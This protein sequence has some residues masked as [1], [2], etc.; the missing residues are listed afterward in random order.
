M[1]YF[2]KYIFIVPFFLFGLAVKVQAIY[3]APHKSDEMYQQ[4]A[5]PFAA[6]MK[7]KVKG[8]TLLNE[9]YGTG[10]Y[11]EDPTTGKHFVLTAAH[12]IKAGQRVYMETSQGDIPLEE[13]HYFPQDLQEYYGER[14]IAL[15]FSNEIRNERLYGG[16][17]DNP[18]ILQAISYYGGDIALGFLPRGIELPIRPLRLSLKQDLPSPS[19]LLVVGFGASGVMGPVG[20]W[21]GNIYGAGRKRAYTPALQRGIIIKLFDFESHEEILHPSWM[22]IA[23]ENNHSPLP[24]QVGY[25]DSGGPVLCRTEAGHHEIIGVVSSVLPAARSKLFK[26]K[27][28][29]WQ[30]F[31]LKLGRHTTPQS[32]VAYA[33]GQEANT[34]G[35]EA[36]FSGITSPLVHDWIRRIL[37]NRS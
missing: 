4:A 37:K 14:K 1:S 18:S 7:L 34:Y 5:F 30:K 27:A 11:V 31:V 22:E 23:E 16:R 19:S 26:G 28:T 10:T 9:G 2:I 32:W 29:E 35:S 12:V 15:S 8:D 33:L 24:G 20:G 21:T 13:I 25:G 17:I 6:V 36:L 3:R